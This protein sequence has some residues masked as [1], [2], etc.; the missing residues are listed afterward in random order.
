MVSTNVV[1]GMV[2]V[3]MD[4]VGWPEDCSPGAREFEVEGLGLTSAELSRLVLKL[5]CGFVP[6]AE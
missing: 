5:D 3:V 6:L 4:F 1:A 2:V